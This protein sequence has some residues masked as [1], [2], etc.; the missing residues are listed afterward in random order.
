MLQA[1]KWVSSLPVPWVEIF[2]HSQGDQI[3]AGDYFTFTHTGFY[4]VL[5]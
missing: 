4:K 2:Q 3:G 5:N 1:S